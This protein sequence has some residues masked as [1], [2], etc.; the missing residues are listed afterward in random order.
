MLS[1]YICKRY[2]SDAVKKVLSLKH[3]CKEMH[4]NSVN[5]MRHL[6]YVVRNEIDVQEQHEQLPSYC[7][8]PA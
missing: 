4:N 5:T 2:Y 7:W 1:W 6:D 8:L 3:T